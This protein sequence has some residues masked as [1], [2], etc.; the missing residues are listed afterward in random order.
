MCEILSLPLAPFSIWHRQSILNR[1]SHVIDI[2]RVYKKRTCTKALS[3]PSELRQHQ[4]SCIFAL[5]RNEFVA[6]K[7]HAV[8]ERGH[9]TH[10]RDSIKGTKFGE[11]ER[12]IEVLDWYRSES[13]E[14]TVDPPNYFMYLRRQSLV[15]GNIC[16]SGDCDLYQ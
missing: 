10:I 8:P 7:V 14:S 3:S 1:S 6:D 15:L 9:Q 11:G 2:P 12:A 4:H 5:T 13:A 16:S